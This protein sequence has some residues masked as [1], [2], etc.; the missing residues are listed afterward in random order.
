MKTMKLGVLLLAFLLA[1]VAMVPM[2][3]AEETMQKSIIN[4]ASD[5]AKDP[6]IVAIMTNATSM[7]TLPGYLQEKTSVNSNNVNGMVSPSTDVGKETEAY[8]DNYIPPSTQIINLMKTKGY[9]NSQITDYLSKNG[10][11][12]DPKTGAN[13]KGVA[14]TAAEQKIIDQIRGPNYSPF[15]ETVGNKSTSELTVST[16]SGLTSDRKGTAALWLPDTNTYFGITF[17]MSP[18]PM[19]ES[20]TGTKQHVVTTHVGKPTSSGQQDW[21]E[22][23]VVRFLNDASPRYF[24][25]DNDEKQWQFHGSDNNGALTNYEIYVTNTQ[26]SLGYICYTYINNQWVRSGHLKN[27]QTQFN[28]ANEVWAEGNN[29]FTSDG[30]VNSIF[31]DP[32]LFG[33]NGDQWWG[34]YPA[35]V[36]QPPSQDQ[37]PY[38]SYRMNGNAYELSSWV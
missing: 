28:M 20:S 12:W 27:R 21:T 24:S 8:L 19:L 9:S 36:S 34:N 26:E 31:R 10:Y 29:A 15:P 22:V 5:P 11:G 6:E 23:G 2:V 37:P 17:S 33:P 38:A 25:Y 14:P 30:G 32:K 35:T 13:W 4:A 3:S 1:A 7:E 16:S 18:G